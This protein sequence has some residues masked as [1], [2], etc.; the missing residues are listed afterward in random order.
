MLFSNTVPEHS[1]IHWA[2]VPVVGFLL[3][4]V[5]VQEPKLVLS[6]QLH[7][8]L[9]QCPVTEN[10]YE[11]CNVPLCCFRRPLHS[12][13][14]SA[15]SVCPHALPAY[16]PVC[17]SVRPIPHISTRDE[18]LKDVSTFTVSKPS[19][20]LYCYFVSAWDE[21]GLFPCCAYTFRIWNYRTCK[22]FVEYFTKK[23]KCKKKKVS[24]TCNTNNRFDC[25]YVELF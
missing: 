19:Y 16:V 22:T 8:V 21:F 10:K 4:N 12:S 17:L 25:I 14:L 13:F 6:G 3:L 2:A 1:Q 18:A 5:L 7:S 11:I 20:L 23:V 24:S 9:T 15:W